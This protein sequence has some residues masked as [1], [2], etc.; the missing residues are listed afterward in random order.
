MR[1]VIQEFIYSIGLG[2]DEV[3]IE[4][5]KYMMM[6]ITVGLAIFKFGMQIITTIVIEALRMRR[7]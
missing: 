5:I 3:T 4:S 2:H 1:E 6:R 7:I